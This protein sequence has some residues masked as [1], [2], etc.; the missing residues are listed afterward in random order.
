MQIEEAAANGFGTSAR[1]VEFSG[2]WGDP[3]GLTPEHP[4]LHADS[5]LLSATSAPDGQTDVP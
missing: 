3:N 5:S 4:Q 1:T 2:G